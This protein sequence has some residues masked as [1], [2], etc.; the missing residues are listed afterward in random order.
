MSG[1]PRGNDLHRTRVEKVLGVSDTLIQSVLGRDYGKPLERK[2]PR[3]AESFSGPKPRPAGSPAAKEPDAVVLEIRRLREDLGMTAS[4]IQA[5]LLGHGYDVPRDRI[6]N[7]F[8][9][10]TRAHLVPQSGRSSYLTES[11]SCTTSTPS[12]N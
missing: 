9:Y 2:R 6:E 8:R 1:K 4:Q 5:S 11:N 10:A 12:R 3:P 7:I